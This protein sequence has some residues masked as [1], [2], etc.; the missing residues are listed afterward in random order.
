MKKSLSLFITLLLCSVLVN[1]QSKFTVTLNSPT[2]AQ[3]IPNG[4]NI[5][6]S[7][8]ITL[9]IGNILPTDTVAYADPFVPSGQVW[10]KTN[11]TKNQGD[12]I[13]INRDYSG[14]SAPA[15]TV[16]YCVL[17]FKFAA[18]GLAVGFDTTGYR[19]CN[20]VTITGIQAT[21]K[22]MFFEKETIKQNLTIT[23]NPAINSIVS[24]DFVA[25]NSEEVFATIYDIAGRKV[26]QH[27]YGKGYDGKTGYQLDIAQLNAGIYVV[28]IAQKGIKSTAKLIK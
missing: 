18:G 4:S 16:D 3:V 19:D 8:V 25:Q 13:Q 22:N 23:P 15:G 7:F 12:T 10:I 26:M 6:E 1:A 14:I 27:N 11:M 9:D 24:F 17:A 20:S 28:E 2:N 21:I 5:T